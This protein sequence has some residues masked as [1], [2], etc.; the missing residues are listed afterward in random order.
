MKPSKGVWRSPGA[1][2]AAGISSR[3]KFCDGDVWNETSLLPSVPLKLSLLLFSGH[4][5]EEKTQPQE[6]AKSS[7]K[8]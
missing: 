5:Q 2:A 4:R 1:E 7:S 3:G 8:R 6:S